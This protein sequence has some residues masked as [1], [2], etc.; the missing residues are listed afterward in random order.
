MKKDWRKEKK[1]E[2][3]KIEENILKKKRKGNNAKTATKK[4]HGPTDQ[5]TKSRLAHHF[6]IDPTQNLGKKRFKL[7]FL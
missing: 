6:F 3:K 2:D 1:K 5:P 4:G 7:N